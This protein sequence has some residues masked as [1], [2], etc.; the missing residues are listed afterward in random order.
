[1]YCPVYN[2]LHEEL[3]I[4]AAQFEPSFNNLNDDEPFVFDN[5]KADIYWNKICR[6]KR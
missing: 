3:F 6:K 5:Y 4:H 1:M 2:E